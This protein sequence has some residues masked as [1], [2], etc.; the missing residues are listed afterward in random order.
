MLVRAVR[1][2][3]WAETVGKDLKIEGG[4]MVIGERES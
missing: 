2:A 1:F 4:T 3:K